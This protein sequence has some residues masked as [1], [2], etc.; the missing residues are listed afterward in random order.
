MIGLLPLIALGLAFFCCGAVFV[1]PRWRWRSLLSL[2]AVVSGLVESD[3]LAQLI[4]SSP[5]LVTLIA[6]AITALLVW[7]LFDVSTFR[8]MPARPAAPVMGGFSLAKFARRSRQ[9]RLEVTKS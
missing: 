8:A 2:A 5:A 9:G 4:Q 7:S 3:R 6:L 1:Q